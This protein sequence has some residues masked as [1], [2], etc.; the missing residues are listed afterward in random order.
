MLGPPQPQRRDDPVAPGQLLADRFRVVRRIA[1]GGMGVVY[2]A[3]DEKLSRPIALKFARGGHGGRLSPEVRLATEVSHPNICNIYEIHMAQS[4]EGPLEFFTM[5]LLEGLTLS[6]RLAEGPLPPKEAETIA[7]QLCAGLA[8]AHRHQIIHGDLKSGNVILAKNPDGT[9]RAVLTDFGLARAAHVRGTR[10]GTPGSMAPELLAGEPTTVASDI[11]ALG[12]ILHELVSGFRP[13]ERAAMLAS[14]LTQGPSDPPSK[15]DRRQR[16]AALSRTL[17]PPLGSRW[18]TVI[19][20]CL[21]E[22]P[23]QR[24]ETVDQVQQAL[25]PSALRR[26]A[27]MFAGAL[28]LAAV[29]AL[30]TYRQSTAPAQTVR[31]DIAAV[32]ASPLLA[33]QA[34]QLRQ[35]AFREMS[36]LK[37]SA[38]IAFSVQ[39]PSRAFQAT[40]RFSADLTEK[41]GKVGLHAVLRDLRSGAPLME[42]AADYAPA[43]LR[44][45]PVAL[46]GVVSSALHLPALTTYATI[47]P[48][49]AASY[50]QGLALLQDD[51]KLDQTLAALHSAATQDPD[52][53]LPFAAL[54]EAQRRRFFLTKLVSWKEEAMASFE[55]A[56]LRNPDCAEGHRIAGLLEYDRSRPEQAMARIRRATEFRPPHPDAFRRLGQLYARNG[57]LSEALQAYSEAQRLAPRDARMYQDLANLYSAQSNFAEASKALQRAVEL[58]PDRQVFRE[59]LAR[60][61][62]DQGRFADAET[63][64]RAMLRQDNSADTQMQL[65]HVLLYQKREA[66]AIPV[67]SQAVSLN[68]RHKFAWLYLG[69]ACQRTGRAADARRAFQH[70]LSVAHQEVT[71]LPRASDGYYHAV[72]AYFCAQTG[73]AERAGVEAVQA[74]QFAPHDNDTLWMTALTYECTGNRAAALKTLEDAPQPLLEDLRRWPEA[75][76]LTSD[77]RFSKLF[78]SNAGRR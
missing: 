16:L 31:L 46:A 35:D 41:G 60:S 13:H 14:T 68:N 19:A 47:R 39:S 20:T 48:A 5:E 54:A 11:Y 1:H 65:G 56:E 67:L 50:Q 40:H 57:Q 26:R 51:N 28:M 66:D 24:Y 45:A 33:A 76:G 7:R 12:V 72:L 78:A 73:Q 74:L 22:D 9:L 58:A 10:G 49:A 52:S 3:F 2:E 55:Q 23:K 36:R 29:A 30:A 18:D 17:L 62:Q 8:E 77:E 25:G 53:A 37:N 42:W 4:P 38:Q 6:Q 34:R 71:Q 32:Q 75:S 27:P 63:E 15:L 70:G 44:Y 43:Q 64:L 59:L 69:I 21:Q 61:Y